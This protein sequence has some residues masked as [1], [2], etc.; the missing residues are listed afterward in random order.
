MIGFGCVDSS[1][2]QVESVAE[3]R[4]RI[5]KGVEIF[6]PKIDA[7]RSRLRD[8]DAEPGVGLLETQ[9]HVRCRKGSADRTVDFFLFCFVETLQK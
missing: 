8:A 3:I 7:H 2:D 5:E 9:E 6:E 1:I 4:K